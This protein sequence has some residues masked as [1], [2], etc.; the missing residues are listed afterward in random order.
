MGQAGRAGA[1]R[2]TQELLAI[3]GTLKGDETVIRAQDIAGRLGCSLDHAR[4]LIYLLLNLR[5]QE[6]TP[7]PLSPAENYDE[8]AVYVGSGTLRGYPLR[9]NQ[10]ETDALVQ[11]L[12]MMGVT[13]TDQVARKLSGSL[14]RERSD[15]TEME[16]RLGLVRASATSPVVHQILEASYEDL[17]LS[18]TYQKADQGTPEHRRVVPLGLRNENEAWYLTA[19]DLDRH[20]NRRFRVDRMSRVES[21][22]ADE[23]AARRHGASPEPGPRLIRLT[24]RNQYLVAGLSWPGMVIEDQGPEAQVGTAVHATVPYYGGAWLLRR[25]ASCGSGVAIEDQDLAEAVRAYARDLLE[26]QED[27]RPA[28]A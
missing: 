22:E 21:F 7:L 24:F 13:E 8:V 3:L 19:F 2:E 17:C 1:Q 18:F 14:S 28:G 23:E 16:R 4:H 12:A 11:A 27:D 15:S 25:L 10:A 20:A 26:G 6:D 5:D 9:L